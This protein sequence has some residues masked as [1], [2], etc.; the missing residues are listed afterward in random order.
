MDILLP[1]LAEIPPAAPV[2]VLPEAVIFPSALLPLYIFEPRYRAMLEAALQTDRMFCVAMA[3]PASIGQSPAQPYYSV[4][5]LGLVRACVGRPD[6]TSHLVLQGVARVHLGR[7][8]QAEPF[9]IAELEEL[10][11]TPV[12]SAEAKSAREEILELCRAVAPEDGEMR[13]KIE[14][15]LEHLPDAGT[16]CDVVAHTFIAD[17]FARQ[18]TLEELNVGLRLQKVATYLRMQK[19][20][21]S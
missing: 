17:P 8:R 11:S 14:S 20:T 1:P 6:G 12:D 5:G 10:R 21:A 7:L 4:S 9:C 15:Q 13:E 18:R 19:G 16:F 2:M 3:R